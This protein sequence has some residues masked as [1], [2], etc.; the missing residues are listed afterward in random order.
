M[1]NTTF[2]VPLLQDG[3]VIVIQG[4]IVPQCNSFSVNL[5]TPNKDNVFHCHMHYDGDASIVRTVM[6]NGAWAGNNETDGPKMAIPKGS[7][8]EIR[9]RC[10]ADKYEYCVNGKHYFD[11]KHRLIKERATSLLIASNDGQNGLADVVVGFEM[12]Q[13]NSAIRLPKL[14][15]GMQIIGRAYIKP[16][17]DSIPIHFITQDD[18]NIALH[19]H[20]H[21][22]FT[23]QVCRTSVLSGKHYDWAPGEE[24]GPAFLVPRRTMAK[25]NFVIRK[26]LINGIINER[27]AF[28]YKHR[29]PIDKIKVAYFV[30]DNNGV[31]Q[32]SWRVLMP[33]ESEYQTTEQQYGRVEII[34]V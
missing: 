13:Y 28:D 10:N 3:T 32:T 34:A 31:E 18:E 22:N 4:T 17:A 6:I 20:C 29:I 5:L 23:N 19:V 27:H 33:G 16:E 21:Y 14:V 24:Y 30:N 25:F 7:R 15:E 12:P 11:F 26:D 1:A 9:I 2:D 8:I